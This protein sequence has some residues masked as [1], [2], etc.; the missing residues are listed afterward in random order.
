[1]VSLHKGFRARLKR[2]VITPVT[3]GGLFLGD[4]H[5]A[6]FRAEYLD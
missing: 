4:S 1:M 5:P 3:A 2:E 6:P